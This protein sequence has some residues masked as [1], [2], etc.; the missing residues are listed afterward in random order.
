[1]LKYEGPFQ[2]KNEWYVSVNEGLFDT[3]SIDWKRLIAI[4]VDR[5]EFD[6][7]D[8]EDCSS[9]D[10][11]K[12]VLIDFPAPKRQEMSDWQKA[13]LTLIL[14]DYKAISDSV[15]EELSR[16]RSQESGYFP[17]DEPIYNCVELSATTVQREEKNC[18]AFLF[19]CDWDT[20]MGVAVRYLSGGNTEIIANPYSVFG[21]GDERD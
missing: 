4:G 12:S 15:I 21:D 2:E 13:A 5:G 3:C 10:R 8:L 11:N 9:G 20:N 7:E 16:I 18:I 19:Q 17:L 1:M 14:N 6:P